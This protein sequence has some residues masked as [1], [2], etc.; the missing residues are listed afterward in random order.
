MRFSEAKLCME[1]DIARVKSVL[2]HVRIRTFS[3][4]TFQL[5]EEKLK[6]QMCL[7]DSGHTLTMEI[8]FLYF[9]ANLLVFEGL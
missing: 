2:Y 1:M 4:V 8:C 3:L 6:N 7:R 5:V 9:A